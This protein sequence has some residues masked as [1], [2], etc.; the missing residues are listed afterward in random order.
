MHGT[1][2]ISALHLSYTSAVQADRS[3]I[4]AMRHKAAALEHFTSHIHELQKTNCHAYFILGSIIS[5]M[6][7]FLIANDNAEKRPV[8]IAQIVLHFKL[9]QGE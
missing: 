2:A 5:M 7:T 6:S 3:R 9:L 8:A 4:F 1:L